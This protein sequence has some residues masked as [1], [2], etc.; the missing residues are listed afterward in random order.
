[1]LFLLFFICTIRKHPPTHQH[2]RAEIEALL[3]AGVT[4]IADRYTYSGIAY[5]LAKDRA[6]GRAVFSYEWCI[7]CERGLLRPDAVVFFDIDVATALA[8]GDAGG[9]AQ[10]RYE[11][12]PF[13]AAVKGV[14]DDVLRDSTF[15]HTVDART[16][17]DAVTDA[18]MPLV[19]QTIAAVC[20]KPTQRIA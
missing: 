9:K 7:A 6:A 8:R 15:W 10:E 11:T 12:S 17:P 5:T 1:M 3:A 2:H 18:V 4:V 14:Y 13:L 19:R 20:D 16:S